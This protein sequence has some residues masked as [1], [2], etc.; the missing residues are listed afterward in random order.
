MNSTQP[1]P[2][3]IL[4]VAWSY[5]GVGTIQLG[6]EQ[7]APASSTKLTQQSF[8]RNRLLTNEIG[9]QW[10]T[11]AWTNLKRWS[12]NEYMSLKD[13]AKNEVLGWRSFEELLR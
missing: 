5:E 1:R 2:T 13:L 8:F 12:K 9:I 3:R 7:H 6:L 4:D 10:G 11:E